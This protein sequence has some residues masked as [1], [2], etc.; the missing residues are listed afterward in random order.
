MSQQ[1]PSFMQAFISFGGVLSIM[2]AGIALSDFELHILLIGALL[3]VCVTCSLNGV[4]FHKLKK[5][6]SAGIAKA[7]GALY[8]FILIGIVIAALIEGGTIPA[9][10]YY[11]VDYVSPTWFLP[12]GLLF[13]SFMSAATGTSWGTVGTIGVVLVGLGSVIGIPLPIVA[14]MVVSGALFG[15]KMSPVSDTTILA[16]ACAETDIY[17]HIRAMSYTTG[18]AYLVSLLLFAAIGLQYDG[19]VAAGGD[20]DAI[21][22]SLDSIFAIDPLALLPILVLMALS[23][24]G[25]AAE[26]TMISASLVAIGLAAFAQDRSFGDIFTSIQYGYSID[27]GVS[28][29]DTLLNRGG[30]QSM[31]WTLSLALIALALGGVLDGV[32]IMRTLTNALI[33]KIRTAVQLVGSTIAT[34]IVVNM[35]M[36]ENYL[37][38]IFSSQIFKESFRNMGLKQRMLSRSVEEGATLTAG[39]IPWTTTGAFFSA[40]LGVTTMQYAPWAFLS[41]INIGVS[42]LMAAFG[43]AIFRSDDSASATQ[44]DTLES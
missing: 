12:A 21:R 22:D 13:T 37:T 34:G 32:G 43:I 18:P 17:S 19:T 44:I 29:V 7:L 28:T 14:G 8:M 31:M 36:G 10:I 35:S 3:W 42:L 25:T 6:M 20:V 41:V 40:S 5:F 30:I 33:R 11:S 1:D 16:A 26:P 38:I 4:R 23:I 9:I 27:S 15:D 24:R 2:I 39:L